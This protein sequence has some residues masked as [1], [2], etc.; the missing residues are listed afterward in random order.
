MKIRCPKCG[1]V[2]SVDGSL[3]FCPSCGAKLAMPDTAKPKE[4]PK[5]EAP[6]EEEKPVEEIKEEPKVEESTSVEKPVVEEAP[7]VAEIVEPAQPAP[8]PQQNAKQVKTGSKGKAIAFGILGLIFG[9]GCLGSNIA[10]LF[11]AN[12]NMHVVAL[13]FVACDFI[14]TF[15]GYLF[16]KISRKQ[17]VVKG[18]SITACIFA[19]LGVVSLVITLSISVTSIAI[20]ASNNGISFLEELTNFFNDANPELVLF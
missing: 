17:N 16:S 10:G 15:L 13:I 3:G 4:E 6:K 8:A 12:V 2:F 1:T 20:E 14:P 9:F 19:A 7:R 18:L 5:V 11:F